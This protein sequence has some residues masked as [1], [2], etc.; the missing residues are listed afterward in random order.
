MQ[1][2]VQLT[3]LQKVGTI[4]THNSRGQTLVVM[5]VNQR[6]SGGIQTKNKTG[7]TLVS[8]STNLAGQG[9]VVAEDVKG[10]NASAIP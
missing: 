6:G 1:G 2:H 8:L 9:R 5:G 7:H 3:S 10:K 4:L